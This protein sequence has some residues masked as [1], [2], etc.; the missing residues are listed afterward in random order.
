M[1]YVRVRDRDTGHE[2]DALE[3]D[4]RIGAGFFVPVKSDRFPAADVIRPAKYN[5]GPRANLNKKE[6]ADNA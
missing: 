5:V 2:F 4:W 6:T 3:T 1:A